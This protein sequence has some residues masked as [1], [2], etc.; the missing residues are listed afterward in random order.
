MLYRVFYSIFLSGIC[1][2]YILRAISLVSSPSSNSRC[3]DG[4]GHHVNHG[5][6]G[7]ESRVAD[8]DGDSCDAM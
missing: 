7:D 1:T 5:P 6:G 2:I 3:S 8:E 4:E